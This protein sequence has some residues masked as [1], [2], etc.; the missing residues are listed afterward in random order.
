MVTQLSAIVQE[1][2]QYWGVEMVS[3][4][5]REVMHVVKVPSAIEMHLCL[6]CWWLR[7]YLSKDLEAIRDCYIAR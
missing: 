1:F 6:Y 2:V 5:D 4:K 7:Q 3:G